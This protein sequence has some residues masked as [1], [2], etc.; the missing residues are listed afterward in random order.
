MHVA[1]DATAGSAGGSVL[2]FSH[3]GTAGTAVIVLANGVSTGGLP[4]LSATYA[5]S[6][7]TALGNV[8]PY[9][10]V[11]ALYAFGLLS[12]AT[13]TAETVSISSTVGATTCTA[14]CTSYRGVAAFGAAVTQTGTT[15]APSMTVA[16]NIAQ[17]VAQA[18]NVYGGGLT[19][20]AGYNQTVRYNTADPSGGAPGS[21]ATVIGD[22]P[23][24][25][26]VLFSATSTTAYGWAGIAVPL[27][28]A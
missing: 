15:S 7:M 18:F 11:D 20:V 1:F 12:A 8:D 2:S 27:I 22:A 10:G 9:A 5:G 17:M 19:S 14:C 6:P 16:S 23:G 13:G 21:N 26:S 3:T 25:S 24:A 28:P 4:V